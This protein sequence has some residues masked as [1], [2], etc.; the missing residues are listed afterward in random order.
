MDS[1]TNKKRCAGRMKKHIGDL[2]LLAGLPAESI[3]YYNAA[4]DQLKSANDWLWLAGCYEG[5]CAASVILLFPE[6]RWPTSLQRNSSF[7][8]GAIPTFS[9]RQKPGGFSSLP[10]GL[11][12]VECKAKAC[13]SPN[14][15]I[16][17]YREAIGHYRKYHSAAVIETEASVKACQVLIHQDKYLLASDFLQNVVSINIQLS[18]EEKIRRFSELSRLYTMIGFHRKAAFY[19]RVAAMRCVTPKLPDPNWSECYHLLLQ[20]LDGYKLSLDP[21]TVPKDRM[22]GWPTLQIQILQELVATSRRMGSPALSVRHMTFLLHVM[23][24]YLS[25]D[26]RRE[27]AA[28]LESLT[29]RCEG[30]PV[31]LALDTGLIIP[32]VNLFNLPKVKSFKLQNLAPHLQPIPMIARCVES[33][34]CGPFIFSPLQLN[35]RE[36]NKNN[37]KMSFKWVEGDVCEVALQVYNPLPFELRVTNMGLLPDGIAFET[38]PTCLSLPPESGPHPVNLL[39]TPRST[40]ELFILGYTTH[41]LGV[42]SDCRLK[43]VPSVRKPRFTIGVVPALPQVQVITSLPKSPVF[44]PSSSSSS[45]AASSSSSS[46][47][48]GS[49]SVVTSAHLT[50]FA[51]ESCDCMVTLVNTGKEDIESLEVQIETKLDQELEKDF[52]AWNLDEIKSRFPVRPNESASFPVTVKAVGDF[53]PPNKTTDEGSDTSSLMSSA[54]Q[55][56]KSKASSMA[57]AATTTTTTTVTNAPASRTTSV[58][59]FG[60]SRSSFTYSSF[61]GKLPDFFAAS[62]RQLPSSQSPTHHQPPKSQTVEAILKVRYSGGPGLKAGYCRQCLVAFSLE[63]V[64]SVIIVKWD[65][66]PAESAA[67]C[68]LVLDIL[69]ATDHEMEMQYAPQKQILIEAR[70]TCRIPVPVQ[71]C[72]LAKLSGLSE[73]ESEK[74]C[75]EHV[76]SLVDLGWSMSG[77]ETAGRASVSSIAWNAAMLDGLK[78]CPLQWDVSLNGEPYGAQKEF[79]FAS[80]QIVDVVVGLSNYSGHPMNDLSLVLQ[81]HQDY[82]NAQVSCRVDGK[83]LVVGADKVFIRQLLDRDSYRHRCA[84]LFFYPGIYKLDVQCRNLDQATTTTTRSWRSRAMEIVV[85]PAT[86]TTTTAAIGR[87]EE[88]RE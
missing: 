59:G 76:A 57:A 52:C 46:V 77:T 51:G 22:C 26:E 3:G 78:M 9:I 7:T 66:L 33:A 73:E 29:A 53:L 32:P 44:P 17:K 48:S 37:T 47:T 67:Q 85:T 65:V 75:R 87:R 45:S 80:G 71:R 23:F 58:G 74:V 82:Q 24:D 54:S 14:E 30:G 36:K 43:D 6:N 86:T 70:N 81:C 15:V 20:T 2:C 62:P 61:R 28:Q 38:F 21:K 4:A 55:M 8:A 69:N 18:E 40:G 25:A 11:D 1:R 35:V 5:L 64:P 72:P 60:T 56:A 79:S 41:V 12:P 13:L 84:L 39:G 27:F 50:L 31:P 88:I 63:I 16:E 10:N 83:L 34:N 68:Y 19:K 49:N 42:K